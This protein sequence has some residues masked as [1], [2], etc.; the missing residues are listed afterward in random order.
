MVREAV[1]VKGNILANLCQPALASRAVA[2]QVF[3][4]PPPTKARISVKTYK[5]LQKT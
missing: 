2:A 5:N 4:V 3:S 1:E